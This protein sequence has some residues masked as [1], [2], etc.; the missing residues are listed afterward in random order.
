MLTCRFYCSVA[1]HGQPSGLLRGLDP[2][3]PHRCMGDLWPI[4]SPLLSRFFVSPSIAW[5]LRSSPFPPLV[6]S[7]C[8]PWVLS[9][10]LPFL[11]P[12]PLSRGRAWSAPR[13]WAVVP[14]ATLAVWT[15]KGGPSASLPTRFLPLAW[16][17][18]PSSGTLQR[19][20]LVGSPAYSASASSSTHDALDVPAQLYGSCRPMELPAGACA[21]ALCGR[22]HEWWRQTPLVCG[23]HKRLAPLAVLVPVF[24]GAHTRC[25]LNE[26]S[27]SL[28]LCQWSFG[29]PYS[30]Y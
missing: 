14:H 26:V 15:P 1:R 19:H 6:F 12:M 30:G 13:G 11:L 22:L 5:C 29:S 3:L 28:L 21:L 10:H 2:L 4:H 16:I 27:L 25:H 20:R 9:P 23:G 7:P 24:K 8:C 17:F 18:T